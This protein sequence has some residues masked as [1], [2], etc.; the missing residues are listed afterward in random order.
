MARVVTGDA[1]TPVLAFFVVLGTGTAIYLLNK[2]DPER[3]DR[4]VEVEEILEVAPALPE[5][6]L[7]PGS[8][9][10]PAA[11]PENP[12]VDASLLDGFEWHDERERN[13]R[14]ARSLAET[15]REVRG[16]GVYV[17][18]PPKDKGKER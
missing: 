2:E 4:A 10:D 8:L 14:F 1:I 17:E 16:L 18:P 7:L 9:P 5:V 6:S 12:G 3:E 15:V 13:R 11:E